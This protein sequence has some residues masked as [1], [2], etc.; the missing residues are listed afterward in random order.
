MRRTAGTGGFTTP[1]IAGCLDPAGRSILAFDLSDKAW[2]AL[3]RENRKARHLRMPCCA[4]AVAL[5]RSP[6]GNPFL[7]HLPGAACLSAGETEAH[8]T[9]KAMAVE[10]PRANGWA[11]TT[12]EAG[13]APSG[14]SWQAD[15]L[16]RR[17]RHLVA[18]E[19][20][21]SKQPLDEIMR[22]Q[23]RYRASG[24]RGLWLLR[25]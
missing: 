14:V 22:R 16:A 8:R 25:R 4:A 20:Q 10:A 12:E 3:A 13:V 23:E 2:Q 21:W 6:R 24:I 18:L 17:G 1:P 15:V 5:K 7:A 9:L 19:V 11:A